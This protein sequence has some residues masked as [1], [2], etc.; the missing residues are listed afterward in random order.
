MISF[1]LP[2]INAPTADG[3]LRQL[4][5]Y[6]Y[7][8]TEQLNLAM[9]SVDVEMSRQQ[10]AISSAAEAT[11]SPEGKL[12]TF[13]S[14]KA[15]IIK[16]ADIINAYSEEITR[17]LDGLYVAKSEFGTYT[18][19]TS[20]K[21]LENSTGITRILQNVQSLTNTVDGIKSTNIATSAYIRTGEL[22]ETEDGIKIYGIEIGQTNTVDGVEAF[23]KFARF[24]SDRLAFYDNNEQEVAYISD[25]QLVIANAEIKG[26]L[27]LGR[28]RI[29]TANG[30][31]VKWVGG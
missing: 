14:V 7:Q 4:R 8:L 26:Y 21:I 12:K 31:T 5:S 9:Q 27:I 25:Y 15:L 13:N 19:E 11:E 6:L 1:R 29:D 30:F 18:E 17:Q 24:T 3:Q 20:Q 23:N 10:T 16:S 2:E 28:F 22:D